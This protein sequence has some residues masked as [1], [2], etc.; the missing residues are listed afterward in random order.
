MFLNSLNYFRAIAI[1]FIVFGHSYWLADYEFTTINSKT[2]RN[3][4][5][6]GTFFFVFISGF[7]FH[8]IFYKK[9]NSRK[10][11]KG[12]FKYV[13]LPYLIM[14][15]L[16]IANYILKNGYTLENSFY[17]LKPI[18]YCLV[19]GA[20]LLAYWYIPF[21]ILVFALSF[22]YIRF[23]K[24]NI[25]YQLLVFCFLSIV[26]VF[27]HRPQRDIIYL[28]IQSL[29]YFT[30]FYLFGIICSEKKEIL[31]SKLVGKELVLLS[32][33]LLIVIL[34]VYVGVVGNYEKP[35]FE[36]DGIDLM[37]VH[38][39]IFCVFFM[40]FLHR[41]ETVKSKFLD[42]VAKNSFGI[43]FIHGYY[44]LIFLLLK[45]RLNFSF[46][47]NS[48]LIYLGVAIIIFILSL[49]TSMLIRKLIPKYSRSIIGS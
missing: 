49:L 32:I 12:K 45:S 3:L 9:F 35:P 29:A 5:A 30:P 26:S 27:L 22:I 6:G 28:A 31:Y 33:G 36:F 43:F 39:L 20:H 14:S 11:F 19:T 40:I 10:F 48:F 46:P 41:F 18:G 34:Q 21:I 4:T 2:I 37:F 7:L 23:I 24:L 17:Y 15:V 47:Q 8:H 42:V 44:I 13:V 16:P 25:K 38:K 1:I